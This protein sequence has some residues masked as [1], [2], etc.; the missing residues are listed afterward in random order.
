MLSGNNFTQAL[1]CFLFH[2]LAMVI[3][4]YFCS[5]ALLWR[6]TPGKHAINLEFLVFRKHFFAGS[7]CSGDLLR[8]IPLLTLTLA[9][10]RYGLAIVRKIS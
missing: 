3:H 8:T 10:P 9:I 5:A 6:S 4:W 7:L 1:L 2:D